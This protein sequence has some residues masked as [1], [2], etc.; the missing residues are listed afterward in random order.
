MREGAASRHP[1]V[2]DVEN[3]RRDDER[4]G[5]VDATVQPTMGAA[6]G[7]KTGEALVELSEKS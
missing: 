6:V 4:A 3:H 7:F 2:H 1:D 5:G